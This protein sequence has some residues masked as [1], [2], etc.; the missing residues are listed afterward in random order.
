MATSV[1]MMKSRLTR[2]AAENL[3]LA[4]MRL[5]L[6]CTTSKSRMLLTCMSVTLS[7][8]FVTWSAT[9]VYHHDVGSGLSSQD[10]FWGSKLSDAIV[11][12]MT[13]TFGVRVPCSPDGA[14]P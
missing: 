4:D 2:S 7:N 9:S 11:A 14:H 3:S 13:P 6:R 8:I 1:T 5:R 10:C 12:G